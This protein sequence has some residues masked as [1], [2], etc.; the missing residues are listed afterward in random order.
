MKDY[1]TKT[2]KRPRIN[3]GTLTPIALL[4]LAALGDNIERII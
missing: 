4:L 1:A 3:W 2:Y